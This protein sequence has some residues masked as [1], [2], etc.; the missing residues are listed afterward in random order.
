MSCAQAS[1]GA[2]RTTLTVSPF[3]S[4]ETTLIVKIKW[5]VASIRR[6]WR[7]CQISLAIH[8]AASG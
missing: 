4:G 1:S 5:P 2:M 3:L 7:E 8:R 6:C